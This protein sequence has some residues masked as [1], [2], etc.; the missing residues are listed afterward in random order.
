MEDLTR[1]CLEKAVAAG[2]SAGSLIRLADFEA[3]KKQWKQAAEHYGQAWEKDKT[4]PVPLYLRGW[5]LR[6]SGREAEGRELTDLAHWLPLGNE[7]L[8]HGLAEALAKHGLTEAAQAEFEL[9][10]RIGRVETWE[11]N[12]V[13]RRRANE[14]LRQH[15]YLRAADGYERITLSC[16]RA[17]TFFKE[18]LAYIVV[19]AVVHRHRAHGR[20]L[21]GQPDQAHKEAQLVLAELPGDIDLA[22]QIVPALEKNG[23]KQEADKLFS[24]VAARYEELCQAY[25][26]SSWGHNSLAWLS[27][28]CHRHLNK[29][30]DHARK[31]VELMP[32][33]P[34]N[35]DTLAEVHFQRGEKAKAV[36]AMKR[37]V[38]LDG[39]NSYFRKQLQRIE[40]GDPSA[41]LPSSEEDD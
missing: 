13:M 37:C 15:D 30:L 17:N 26:Q 19:P 27:V 33:N 4:Q 40:A 3:E 29:A 31:A 1:T 14:A 21:A 5:A 7:S 34:S 36:E 16:L 18:N 39:K 25:P 2:G 9:I 32:A 11:F 38:E 20:L 22:V 12:D 6:Q 28:C 24:Q 10:P 8:R 23:R 35:R 41:A